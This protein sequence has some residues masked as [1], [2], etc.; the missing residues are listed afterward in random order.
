MKIWGKK[1]MRHIEHKSPFISDHFTCKCI[2]PSNQE[3]EFGRMDQN[4][5]SNHKLSTRELLEI[6]KHKQ[7]E[8]ER[9]KVFHANNNRRE[10][11]WLY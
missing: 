3:T 4:T 8:N 11:E 9:M 10:H 5:Q 1:A 2:K 6:R 7:V